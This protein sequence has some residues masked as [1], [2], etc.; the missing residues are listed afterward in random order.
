MQIP[1]NKS[2][3]LCIGLDKFLDGDL[4]PGEV[5]AF[6]NHLETCE[7]C[8][9]EVELHHA[10]ESIPPEMELPINFH[11]VVAAN[12]ESQVSGLRKRKERKTTLAIISGLGV[13]LFLLL[14]TNAQ[15]FS[16]LLMFGLEQ[17]GALMRVAGGFLSNLIFGVVVIVKVAATEGEASTGTLALGLALVGL[18]LFSYLFF[19]GRVT[20]LRDAKR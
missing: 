4:P 13:A 2:D 20:R 7:D 10:I 3:N 6:S 9:I 1:N 17:I 16:G 8:S 15:A 18:L 11:Q 19:S 5:E 14:G 12:A